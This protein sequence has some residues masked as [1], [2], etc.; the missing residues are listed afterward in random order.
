M[1]PVDLVHVFLGHIAGP[2]VCCLQ[3]FLFVECHP[4]FS[5]VPFYYTRFAQFVFGSGR[6]TILFVAHL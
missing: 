3:Y 2:Y 1:N 6:K 5:V 4:L